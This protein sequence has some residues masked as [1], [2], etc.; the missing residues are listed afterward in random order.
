VA[1]RQRDR[2]RLDAYPDPNFHA[3]ADPGPDPYWPILMLILPN[4]TQVVL[5]FSTVSKMSQFKVFWTAHEN[6]VGKNNGL[7]TFSSALH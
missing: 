7:L 1:F 4:F 6:F 2:H 5:S 3:E